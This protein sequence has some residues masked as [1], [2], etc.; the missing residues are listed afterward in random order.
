MKKNGSNSY[1]DSPSFNDN[2]MLHMQHNVVIDK[3]AIF[4]SWLTESKC[5]LVNGVWVF[6]QSASPERHA[7]SFHVFGSG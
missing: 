7:K 6:R 3:Q 1:P 5:R 2:I 4:E